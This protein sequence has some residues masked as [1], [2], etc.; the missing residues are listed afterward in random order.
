MTPVERAMAIYGEEP[1]RRTFDED[2]QLHLMYGYVFSTPTMF[3][4][5]RP[6]DRYDPPEYIVTPDRRPLW[7]PNAWLIYLAAG[8][9]GEFFR[10]CPYPLPWVGWERKNKL[11]F[12][13]FKRAKRKVINAIEA[14]REFGKVSQGR[15]G[16]PST[17]TQATSSNT[18]GGECGG[19][20]SGQESSG[21]PRIPVLHPDVWDGRPGI[22]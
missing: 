18:G 14:N 3:M 9:L 13:D 20:E 7:G 12:Y 21:R 2:L 11:R 1:C 5:G 15:W 22:A 6:V 17:I 10:Y 16:Q 8:D 19:D 4:M